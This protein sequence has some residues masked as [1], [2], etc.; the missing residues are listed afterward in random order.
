[1]RFHMEDDSLTVIFEG[2]EQ[3]WALKRRLVV[4]KADISHAEWLEGELL[5]RH[6]LGWHAGG[7]GIPGVL[8]A[9]R[10]EGRD[11]L[12]FVYLQHPTRGVGGVKLRHVLTLE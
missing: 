8:Y 12:N 5:P 4:P 2:G 6:E 9:G 1:M 7:T 11:G 10:F 3:F